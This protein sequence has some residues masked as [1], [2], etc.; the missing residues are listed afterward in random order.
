MEEIPE[1][2]QVCSEMRT[3]RYCWW[4]SALVQHLWRGIWPSLWKARILVMIKAPI[5]QVLPLGKRSS[6]ILWPHLRRHTP[7]SSY[8]PTGV[9][10]LFIGTALQCDTRKWGSSGPSWRLAT[11]VSN[12]K[13]VILVSNRTLNALSYYLLCRWGNGGLER[14]TYA[15]QG[16]VSSVRAGTRTRPL[17]LEYF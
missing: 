5:Y 11:I 6:C 3:A 1:C 10:A 13:G 14:F 9:T 4:R 16:H 2:W 17:R 12:S 15:A 8:S 7:C